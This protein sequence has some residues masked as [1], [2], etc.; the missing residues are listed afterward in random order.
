M[1]GWRAVLMVV[2]RYRMGRWQ[3]RKVSK[4]LAEPTES[5]KSNEQGAAPPVTPGEINDESWLEVDPVEAMVEGV[6]SRG[7]SEL[8]KYVKELLG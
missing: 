8:L 7:G 4:G 6:K 3:R 1:E 2:L 5:D